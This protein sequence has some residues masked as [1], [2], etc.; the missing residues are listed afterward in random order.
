MLMAFSL[1][2]EFAGPVAMIQ[3]SDIVYGYAFQVAFFNESIDSW[4]LIG[5]AMIT[6]LLLYSSILKKKKV[7]GHI[8]VC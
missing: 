2:V 4:S 5:G 6:L 3:A 8:L 7:N 1:S